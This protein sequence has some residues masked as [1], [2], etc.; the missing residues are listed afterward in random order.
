MHHMSEV[1]FGT[2]VSVRSTQSHMNPHWLQK[3]KQPTFFVVIN[4]INAESV[5][6]VSTVEML[7]P[8]CEDH[9]V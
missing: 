9:A 1:V 6:S 8:S 3:L 5:M 7:V 2:S 4:N